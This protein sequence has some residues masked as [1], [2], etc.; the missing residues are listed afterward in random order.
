M[1]TKVSN[2][3]NATMRRL[4]FITTIFMPLTLIASI[5]GMSEYTM[6]TGGDNWKTSY[7]LLTAGLVLI[8][9]ISYF[10]LRSLERR[11]KRH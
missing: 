8:A 10:F 5:G 11:K 4:T 3:T 1:M 9:V 7:L 6:I 2:E